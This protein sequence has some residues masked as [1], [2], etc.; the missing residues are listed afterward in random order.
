VN[1]CKAD[2]VQLSFSQTGER[3]AAAVSL[4]SGGLWPGTLADCCFS[5]DESAPST[6]IVFGCYTFG[7]ADNPH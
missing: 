7:N 1:E 5:L 3:P 2:S 4:I 6:M